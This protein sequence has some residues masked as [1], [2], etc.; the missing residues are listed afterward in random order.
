[1]RHWILG[2]SITLLGAIGCGDDGGG[3]G[4]SGSS[5][6]AALT[7]SGPGG[8]S[9]DTS[10]GGQ[11]T[12]SSSGTT[13]GADTTAGTTGGS[14]S[15]TTDATDGSGSD[16]AGSSSGGQMGTLEPTMTNLEI[17]QNCQPI[18]DPD[19]VGA[20]FTLE[21]VNPS[22]AVA[23]AT[24]VS[25]AFMVPGGVQV[26]TIDVAP[27]AFGPVGAGDNLMQAVAK[28]QDSLMP[29]NGCAV[30]QCNMDYTLV[31]TLDVDGTEIVAQDTAPAM[32][33]F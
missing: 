22:M 11:T 5:S 17:F 3:G 19:P 28:V 10:A 23:S 18:V 1:M 20:S 26:A 27:A 7:T 32:C 13:D 16:G 12:S 30:L 9:S 29:A 25:A 14:D 15:G 4:T 2:A 8:S 33:A 24:V 21:L 31:L 6:T